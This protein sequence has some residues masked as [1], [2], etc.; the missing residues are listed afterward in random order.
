MASVF[1]ASAPLVVELVHE[2]RCSDVGCRVGHA[3]V[4]VATVD[5]VMRV[6]RQEHLR[7]RIEHGGNVDDE[8]LSNCENR[9]YD[10]I[11]DTHDY[12]ILCS[13]GPLS[14]PLELSH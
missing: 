2:W 13:Y 3:G 10:V 1:P 9:E 14:R 11:T 4:V 7:R 8:F 5:A 12:V 6:W